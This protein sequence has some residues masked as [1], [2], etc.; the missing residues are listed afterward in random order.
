M[1][2]KTKQK[3]AIELILQEQQHPLKPIEI[4]QLALPSVPSL[5]IATVYRTLKQL[6]EEGRVTTLEL[7]G[8]PPRYERT[9]KAHHHHFLCLKCHQVFELDECLQGI[10][11]LAPKTFQVIDHEINLYGYCANCQ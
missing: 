9:N 3:K 7:P 4:H 1:S 8:E 5:G 2:R 10:H 11:Q 6:I